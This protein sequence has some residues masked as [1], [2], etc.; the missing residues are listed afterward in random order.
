MRGTP[1]QLAS[2]GKAAAEPEVLPLQITVEYKLVVTPTRHSS[3]SRRVQTLLHGDGAHGGNDHL[4]G[5]TAEH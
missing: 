2:A 3:L 5:A 4:H 1:N